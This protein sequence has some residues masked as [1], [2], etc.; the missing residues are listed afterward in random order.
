MFW[1]RIKQITAKDAKKL[2]EEKGGLLYD[3]RQPEDYEKSHAKGALLANKHRIEY[4]IETN[5]K[6]KPVICYCYR[7]FSSRIACRQLMNA[8]FENVWNLKG[9]YAAWRKTWGESGSEI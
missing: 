9:G 1:K 5:D 8:G 6:T 4:F 2:L 7:G 3:V